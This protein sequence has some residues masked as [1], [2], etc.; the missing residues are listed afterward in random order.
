MRLY[1]RSMRLFFTITIVFSV[2]CLILHFSV[3]IPDSDFWCNV[4]L[5][6][7][8]GGLISLATACMGY[9]DERRKTLE[10]FYY[11]TKELLGKLDIYSYAWSREKKIEFFLRFCEYEGLANEFEKEYGNISFLLDFSNLNRMYIYDKIYCPLSCLS[12]L[13]M[14]YKKIFQSYMDHDEISEEDIIT[15]ILNIESY[16]LDSRIR[17]VYVRPETTFPDKI[18]YELN[19]RF[20][21]ILY[22]KKEK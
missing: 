16:L 10:N 20:F 8:G 15:C 9:F 6:I 21:D 2:I 5:T 17:S 1:V 11:H 4:A 19:G 7:A 12:R 18:R 22:M 14:Y 3:S 13:I